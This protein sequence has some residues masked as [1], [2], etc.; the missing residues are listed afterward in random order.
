M[1]SWT[2]AYNNDTKLNFAEIMYTSREGRE[3]YDYEISKDIYARLGTFSDAVDNER[4]IKTA[5]SIYSFEHT[6]YGTLEPERTVWDKEA[7][8]SEQ[9]TVSY[10]RKT[11]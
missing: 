2:L 7:M 1:V 6:M 4:L 11:V 9:T 5:K 10:R 8:Q 3:Q